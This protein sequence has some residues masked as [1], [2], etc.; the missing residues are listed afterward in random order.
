MP[1]IYRPITGTDRTITRSVCRS[2]AKDI[3]KM[4]GYDHPYDIVFMNEMTGKTQRLQNEYNMGTNT[5]IRSR[6]ETYMMIEFDEKFDET[7]VLRHKYKLDQ[8]PPVF[9]DDTHGIQILPMYATAILK[10]TFH[11]R[12]N[13]KTDLES[14]IEKLRLAHQVHRLVWFHDLPYLYKLNDEMVAF[15]GDAYTAMAAVDTSLTDMGTYLKAHFR[16]EVQKRTNDTK[17]IYE[18]YMGEVQRD[19]TGSCDDEYFYN[20]KSIN[21]NLYEVTIPYTLEYFKPIALKLT[22]PGTIGNATLPEKYINGWIPQVDRSGTAWSGDIVQPYYYKSFYTQETL[23]DYP[24]YIGDGGSRL[25]EWDDW[26]PQVFDN[27]YQTICITPIMVDP[28]NPNTVVDL[29]EIPTDYFPAACLTY[30]L[31][32][33][34]AQRRTPN[35][36]IGLELFEVTDEETRLVVTTSD[37]GIVT[38]GTDNPLDVTKRYYLRISLFRDLS[39]Y[40]SYYTRLLL[41]EAD[42]ALP[43]FELYD[44]TV[45]IT[46]DFNTWRSA[47]P[48]SLVLKPGGLPNIDSI[49]YAPDGKITDLSYSFWLKKLQ[50]VHTLFKM[51]TPHADIQALTGKFTAYRRR[52]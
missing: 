52:R 39:L 24:F 18:L 16:D 17:S 5:P 22:F 38:T 4:T 32:V 46:T 37:E 42:V 27:K 41:D 9:S 44:N 30:F 11:L 10:F 28:D 26:F 43:I 8:I 15:L 1:V 36:L 3:L 34:Q 49:L 19:V 12:S 51:L 20:T 35:S 21:D 29:T 47:M 31:Q 23:A 45:E 40:S 14:W 33:P 25:R 2:I 6:F 48:D 50:S 13:S 7:D